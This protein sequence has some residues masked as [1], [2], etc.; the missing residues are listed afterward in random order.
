MTNITVANSDSI[1]MLIKAPTSKNAN[2]TICQMRSFLS[3]DCSTYYNVSGMSGGRLE[4]RCGT[5]ATKH[6]AYKDSVHVDRSPPTTAPD[7]RNVGSQWMLALSLNT[8]ISDANSSTS[9]LLSQFIPSFESWSPAR[10]RSRLLPSMAEAL[11]V[12][13]GSTLLRSSIDASYFHYWGYE[14]HI[15]SPGVDEKFNATIT[16]Q[17]YT[18][19]VTQKWQGVFYIVLVLIFATNVFCLTY[20]ILRNGLVTDFTEL[21]N[22]FSL[23]VNSPPSQRLNGSCGAG[24]A[25]EQLNVDFH[26]LEEES[27]HLFVKEGEGRR[28]GGVEMKRRRG[29]IRHPHLKSRSSYGKLSSARSSWL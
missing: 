15:L 2:Y 22:L 19:G 23:A 16:S 5:N 24:P 25:G 6:M 9:R 10:A 8:G 18:S 21:Q 26:V 4:S 14:S 28:S 20:F 7:W 29:E 27:G 3:F 17:Q 12:M 13:G 1:Y 11:A